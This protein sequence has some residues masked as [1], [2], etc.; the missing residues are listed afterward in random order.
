M[1]KCNF[2][3]AMERNLEALPIFPTSVLRHSVELI[4][5]STL[6]S[7]GYEETYI[8][9]D[10]CRGDGYVLNFCPECGLKLTKGS[11]IDSPLDKP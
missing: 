7:G 4:S 2:C 3:E 9:T 11:A 8:I 5:K 6:K 10:D 1:T